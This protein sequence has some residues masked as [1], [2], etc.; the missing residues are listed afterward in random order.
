MA[1]AKSFRSLVP[2]LG[3]ALLIAS[4][5]F[6]L[7]WCEQWAWGHVGLEALVLAMLLGAAWRSLAFLPA[8]CCAGIRFAAKPLMEVAIVLMGASVNLSAL[9]D[10]G[11]AMI[12]GIAIAIPLTI[13]VSYRIGL[14]LGLSERM[15]MLVAC[16]NAICGNSAIAAVGPAIGAEAEETSAAIG[17][18]AVMGVVVVLAV[19]FVAKALGFEPIAGGILAGMTVYAVPQVLAAAH[20]LGAVAVQLGA[21]VKLVRVLMLGPVVVVAAL[22]FG[23]KPKSSGGSSARLL[24]AFILLFVLL[25]SLHSLGLIPL[26]LAQAARLASLLLTVVAMAGL[27]LGVDL[28]KLAEAGPRVTASVV[29][30]LAVLFGVT[31][32]IIG[33]RAVA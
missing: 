27:G 14:A 29:L 30:S 18:T 24:P 16:G 1:Y 15:A 19:P 8:G 2:G 28:R 5:A 7:E 4:A 11:M 31:F 9:G 21:L 10:L 33:L 3:L 17:Y 22:H 20:P 26:P 12:G 23:G 6:A 25:A 13:A 32:L